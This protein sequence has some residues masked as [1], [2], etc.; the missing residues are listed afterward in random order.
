MSDTKFISHYDLESIK[1]LIECGDVFITGTAQND[2]EQIG[3]SVEDIL[4]TVLLLENK[5]LYKSMRSTKS[6][7]LWQDVYHFNDD[8]INLYIKLQ[9]SNNAIVIS[10]KE[11]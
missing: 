3:M 8:D 11:K 10:F 9:I 4:S 1:A 7:T 6:P 2:A 5:H